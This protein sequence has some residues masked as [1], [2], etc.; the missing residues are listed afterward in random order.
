MTATHDPA[1]PPGIGQFGTV[2]VEGVLGS[3]VAAPFIGRAD[4]RPRPPNS[5]QASLQVDPRG[6][7]FQ[8]PSLGRSTGVAFRFYS[9]E[10]NSWKSKW[11][12]EVATRPAR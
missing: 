12:P 9:R 4:T 1:Q 11:Q 2:S 7:V 5:G 6:A 3:L 8:D 10:L